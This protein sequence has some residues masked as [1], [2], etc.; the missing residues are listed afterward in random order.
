M[1]KP[2][3]VGIVGGQLIDRAGNFQKLPAPQD[4]QQILRVLYTAVDS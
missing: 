2:K 1:S 4:G 3:M